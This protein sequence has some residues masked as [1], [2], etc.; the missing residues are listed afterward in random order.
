MA[1]LTYTVTAPG[2][3]GAI[4]RRF[5]EILQQAAGDLA[6]KNA[7]GASVTIVFDNAPSTGFA[8]IAVAGGTLAATRT[9][10]V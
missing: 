2:E 9:V 4:I 5:G 10:T 6:D 1:T 7:S 3:A 8:T